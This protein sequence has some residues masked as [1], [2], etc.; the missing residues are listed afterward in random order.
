[1]HIS[2]T[3]RQPGAHAMLENLHLLFRPCCTICWTW[4]GRV[5]ERMLSLG[6]NFQE[7]LVFYSYGVKN[8]WIVELHEKIL[9][10]PT[11]A[12]KIP[13]SL[14]W[15]GTFFGD[16]LVGTA[17]KKFCLSQAISGDP[18]LGWQQWY[19]LMTSHTLCSSWVGLLEMKSCTLWLAV[20]PCTRTFPV[21]SRKCPKLKT[22][23]VIWDTCEDDTTI[24]SFASWPLYWH[25]ET[26]KLALELA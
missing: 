18:A 12:V 6:E 11:A 16:R 2:S 21:P 20:S 8:V 26:L 23:E 3:P 19:R 13:F 14:K 7:A 24:S 5:R 4:S 1:M 17:V 22:W 10:F 15:W 25:W 9:F